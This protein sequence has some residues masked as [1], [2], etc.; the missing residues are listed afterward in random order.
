MAIYT[1]LTQEDFASISQ[2]FGLGRVIEARLIPQG[3]INT[4]AFLA[5]ERGRFF[6]RHTTV[7]SG[8]DLRFEAELLAHLHESRFPAPVMLRTREGLP[9]VERA[10]GRACVFSYV[11]GEELTRA[12][13][14]PEHAEALGRQLGKLHRVAQSFSGRRQNPYG[15]ATVRAW[16]QELSRHPNTE[17]VPLAGELLGYLEKAVAFDRGLAPR[18]VIH[19]DL[20]MDNVKWLG[21][22]VSAF[23]DFEMACFDEWALDVAVT[24]NAWCFDGRYL[25]A[26]AKG[27]VRGYVEERPF[28]A[29][30]HQA[31]FAQALF[32]AVRFAASRIRDFHLSPLPPDKLARKD[33]RTYLS[34]ARALAAMGPDGFGALL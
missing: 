34:R 14:T 5:C 25:K 13:F 22:R 30:E 6:L 27:L 15:Q 4:N 16:L 12:S 2:A 1:Q 20:F 3:S 31:L 24:L 18:G 33:F 21:S 8:D 26:H 32:G 28:V 29:V 23:I 7:R 17:L 11:A 10:G 9:F 19:A